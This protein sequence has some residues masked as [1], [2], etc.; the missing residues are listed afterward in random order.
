MDQANLQIAFEMKEKQLIDNIDRLI[1][2]L[3]LYKINDKNSQVDWVLN[4]S[5]EINR[6]ASALM[7]LQE[8]RFWANQNIEKPNSLVGT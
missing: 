8:T 7:A 6:N 4:V 3:S 2:T 1:E 5:Y